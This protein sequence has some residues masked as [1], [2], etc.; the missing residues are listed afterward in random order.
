MEINVGVPMVWKGEFRGLLLMG[1]SRSAGNVDLRAR[2][3]KNLGRLQEVAEKGAEALEG[4]RKSNLA[5][6]DVETGARKQESFEN[7]L[8][9]AVHSSR[10]TRL[11][12]ALLMVRMDCY[13]GIV[14][15]FGAKLA[16]D[17]LSQ[18]VQVL[19]DCLGPSS[20]AM[21]CRLED[22]VFAVIAP[23]CGN[24]EA[25][26]LAQRLKASIDSMRLSRNMPRPTGCV[27]FGVMPDHAQDAA[28]LRRVT[29]RAFQDAVYLDGNRILEAESG[30]TRDSGEEVAPSS[31]GPARRTAAE[32]EPDSDEEDLDRAVPP[33]S[34]PEP[35][36]PF[37]AVPLARTP[38]AS[39]L[40]E[41]KAGGAAP[42]RSRFPEESLFGDL[43][44]AEAEEDEE[45][46][47]IWEIPE[48]PSA[49]R[50]YSEPSAEGFDVDSTWIVTQPAPPAQPAAPPPAP[51]AGVGLLGRFT[52]PP[53][54]APPPPFTEAEAAPP[55][56]VPI[57][58]V[59][60]ATAV[61]LPRSQA[62]PEEAEVAQDELDDLGI[63]SE[64]GFCL[65][66]TFQDLAEFEVRTAL[67]AGDSCSVV[68]LRLANLAELKARGAA[69]YQKLRRD[70]TTVVQTFLRPDIDVPGLMGPDEF[71]MLLTR[72]TLASATSLAYQVA[73]A[74]DKLE[75]SGRKVRS[76]LG[77]AASYPEDP[78]EGADLIE[79]AR[80]AAGKGPGV[81]LHGAES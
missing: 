29:D 59:A 24:R 18:L 17:V 43:G 66:P 10:T 51:P 5:T 21:L 78:L 31:V 27:A 56:S 4:L 35:Y 7:L 40:L 1:R 54:S 67:D 48:R 8:A 80:S 68:Y 13:E 14:E 77:V 42:V 79:Q 61:P 50:R 72:T 52:P 64:T 62:Q 81:H 36:Q 45:A 32:V 60:P 39:E 44:P 75:A 6:F 70:L 11:P 26:A 63:D 37:K 57:P 25:P 69:Q 49:R 76:S 38:K 47:T 2:F 30:G 33:A 34:A 16:S 28:S 20:K 15:N 55:P 9:E 58:V 74:L 3:Q 23:E 73:L 65:E 12:V 46:P 22:G 53:R 41:D 19:Q 71:A